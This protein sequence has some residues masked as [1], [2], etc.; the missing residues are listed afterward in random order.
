M[1]GHKLKIGELDALGQC[2]LPPLDDT[3]ANV[4]ETFA[5]FRSSVRCVWTSL[6]EIVLGEPV[7]NLVD[8]YALVDADVTFAPRRFERDGRV[9]VFEQE[10]YR[11]LRPI[12]VRRQNTVDIVSLRECCAELAGL[13][14]TAVGESGG[15][16]AL[17]SLL[18][19]PSGFT[20]SDCDYRRHSFR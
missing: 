20:V 16:L 18:P 13:L 8:R 11:L 5:A 15:R 7:R 4:D 19:V 12:Q 10:L 2:R 14:S 6:F 9:D 17:Q 3:F 1:E